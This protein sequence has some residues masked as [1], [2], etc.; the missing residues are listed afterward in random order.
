MK[1]SGKAAINGFIPRF[2]LFI[3]PNRAFNN[4]LGHKI[5]NSCHTCAYKLAPH[6]WFSSVA[7]TITC[8]NK[9]REELSDT[10]PLPA[11]SPWLQPSEHKRS[12]VRP[13]VECGNCQSIAISCF[14]CVRIR[15]KELNPNPFESN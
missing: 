3:E 7:Q 14:E 13:L 12:C 8:E 15:R 5:K 10:I 1:F 2:F 4:F 11:A 6:K 9:N